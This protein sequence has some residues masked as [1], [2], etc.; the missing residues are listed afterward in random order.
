MA[1][2]LTKKVEVNVVELTVES[3]AEQLVDYGFGEE[4]TGEDADAQDQVDFGP[5]EAMTEDTQMGGT[6]QEQPSDLYDF[7]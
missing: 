3:E 4:D 5:T 2:P 6:S 1:P 7:D